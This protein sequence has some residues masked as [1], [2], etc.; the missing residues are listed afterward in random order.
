[1]PL[2]SPRINL[3]DITASLQNTLTHTHIKPIKDMLRFYDSLSEAIEK[4]KNAEPVA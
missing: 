1:M 2:H 3:T 4:L